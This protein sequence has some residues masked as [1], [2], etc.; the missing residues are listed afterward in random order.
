VKLISI[1]LPLKKN[2]I[3]IIISSCNCNIS[4]VLWFT[5]LPPTKLHSY[6]HFSFN[7]FLPKG[8][9]SQNLFIMK[10]LMLFFM[11]I[12]FFGFS[13]MQNVVSADRVFPKTGKRPEFEK[14]LAA[15]AQKFHTGN[16]KWR[17]FEIM[18][19]P[20][21]K[22]FHITEGPNSWAVL[23]SR[24]E[25]SKEHTAD[26]D[27]N[28][29]PTI[30]DKRSSTF[31]VYN[32][33]LSTVKL[34]DWA[35]NI[36][37]SHIYPKPG[38]IDKFKELLKK[39]KAAWVAGNESMA[40]YESLA[41]GSPQITIVTRLKNGLKELEKDY[42]TPFKDRYNTAN[43]ANGYDDYLKTFSECIESRWS[44]MLKYRADLS[45]K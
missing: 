18:T 32:D 43:S 12:P 39:S 42:R 41:S 1:A 9:S 7:S 35:D 20:D 10:K 26:W 11:L 15:H 21:A 5:F 28:V 34:T 27:Q 36:I 31:A 14:A 3:T 30:T 25:I 8:I 24:G 29:V 4:F 44:E 33:E 19:G 16:W 40:V 38:M 22:G 17:V 23:D 6:L 45:S 37:I 2:F 13:Q